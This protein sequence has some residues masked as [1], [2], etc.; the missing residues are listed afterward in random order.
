MHTRQQKTVKASPVACAESE[1]QAQDADDL[2]KQLNKL[3]DLLLAI[4]LYNRV[5]HL[6][7]SN[8]KG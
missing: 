1:K 5:S 6:P 7:G 2:Y 3:H 4:Y 8:L